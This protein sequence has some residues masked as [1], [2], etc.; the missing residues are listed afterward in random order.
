MKRNEEYNAGW[1]DCTRYHQ[2]T[3]VPVNK[4]LRTFDKFFDKIYT[5]KKI[6]KLVHDHFRKE[7][8][9]DGQPMLS[10]DHRRSNQEQL[11]K[12]IDNLMQ[13]E[14]KVKNGKDDL[15]SSGFEE[16]D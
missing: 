7:I 8:D 4:L 14:R 16:R 9:I 13:I 1:E 3:H 5:L 6:L 11:F 15:E 2:E 12:I 10:F